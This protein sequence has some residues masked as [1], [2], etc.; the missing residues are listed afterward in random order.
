MRAGPGDGRIIGFVMSGADHTLI[1]FALRVGKRVEVGD[2]VLIRHPHKPGKRVLARVML[3]R[4]YNPEM[5][6]GRPGPHEASRGGRVR[7]GTWIEYKVAYAEPLGYYDEKGRWR[8]LEC[9]PSSWEPVF[10]PTEEELLEFFKPRSGKGGLLVKIG[11]VSKHEKI[12]VQIDL[13][14]VAKGHMFICGMTRSVDADEPILVSDADAG[15]VVEYRIGEFVDAIIDGRLRGRYYTLA[16]SP[17]LRVVWAPVKAVLRHEAPEELYLVRTRSGRSIRVTGDHSVLVLDEELLVRSKEV[18]QL[19]PGDYLLVPRYIPRPPSSRLNPHL[20]PFELTPELAELAGYYVAEGR[21]ASTGVIRISNTNPELV[22]RVREL[23]HELGFAF[24]YNEERG[25][26]S[27]RGPNLGRVF[28]EFFGSGAAGKKVPD[29]FLQLPDRLLLPF[30]SAYLAGDG[31]FE[32]GR[33]VACTKSRLL[34]HRLA[35]L[36]KRLAVHSTLA[37]R[38]KKALNSDHGGDL[39]WLISVGHDAR[40]LAELLRAVSPALTARRIEA[41]LRGKPAGWKSPYEAVPFAGKHIAR[42]RTMLRWRQADLAAAS[43]LTQSAISRIELGQRRPFRESLSRLVQALRARLAELRGLEEDIAFLERLTTIDEGAVLAAL[44]ELKDEGVPLREAAEELGWPWGTVKRWLRG[45]GHSSLRILAFSSQLATWLRSRGLEHQAVRLEELTVNPDEAVSRMVRCAR[46]LGLQRH[47]VLLRGPTTRI[48]TLKRVASRVVQ[49]YRAIDMGLAEELLRRLEL[50]ASSDLIFDEVVSMEVVE[51]TSP[52]VYDLSVEGCENFLSGFGGIFVH[53]SGKS[54]F[55]VNLAIHALSTRPRPR[56]I[57][58]DRRGEYSVLSDYGAL[59]FDY[60][61]FLPRPRDIEPGLLA[62]IL[63]D[64]LGVPGGDKTIRDY[65]G[66]VVQAVRKDGLDFT[67]EVLEN[68][69]DKLTRARESTRERLRLYLNKERLERLLLLEPGR[70]CHDIVDVIMKHPVV[71][72]DLS[73]DPN[74]IY[75][76]L[77]VSKLIRRVV[78]YAMERAKAKEPFAAIFVVEEAQYIAPE[79]GMRIQV[80]APEKLGADKALIEGVSQAGG[81]N[82]GFIIMTQRPAYVAKSVISQCNTILCFRLR[83]PNDQDTVA[84]YTEY[85]NEHLTTYLPGLAD[86]EGMLC[87]MASTIPFPVMVQTHVR[88]YPR[89]AAVTAREAW[90]YMD[91][92]VGEATSSRAEEPGEPQEEPEAS[93]AAG[94]GPAL[95]VVEQGQDSAEAEAST[96]GGLKPEREASLGGAPEAEEPGEVPEREGDA[97]ELEGGGS[98]EGPEG[99]GQGEDVGAKRRKGKAIFDLFEPAI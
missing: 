31:G 83:N 62:E 11:H 84:R 22:E 81:Y 26:C 45:V 23:A 63:A 71:V 93:V 10:E 94:V 65:I 61:A 17:D 33:V 27:V 47:R 85:G 30:L 46:V 98:Q 70:K 40:R 57:I 24:R 48:S 52:Y 36:L 79:K 44:R 82:V 3:V 16:V 42:V 99:V 54:T 18:R 73:T 64:L 53:N 15:L 4:P 7:Y 77:T 2:Y 55:V 76:Q 35:L 59:V 89:K 97:E 72:V 25:F 96:G 38:L 41:G 69:V 75:Q 8:S 80:G 86:F 9:A 32:R 12:P 13:S 92:E 14:E 95:E 60:R 28:E 50:V 66:E 21:V 37:A 5:K 6:A 19:R 58:I 90:E 56:I 39:Y 67:P 87:G 88:E 29:F 51:P 74:T 49:A 1:P 20:G 68:Y 43:G 78:H 91:M 34:A